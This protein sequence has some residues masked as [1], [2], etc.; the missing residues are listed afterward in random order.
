MADKRDY[1]EVLGVEKSAN[2]DDVKKAYRKLAKKFHPDMHT[3]N[4][5]EAEEKFKEVSEAYEVL[6]DPQKRQKYDQ[7]GFSGINGAFGGDGFQWQ[8][9][10]HQADVSDIF[11]DF[12]GGSIFDTFFGGGGRRRTNSGPARGSDLRLDIQITLLE[13][14][15]GLSKTLDIPHSVRCQECNGS[16]AEKGSAP[17]TCAT[18]SGSGQVKQVQRR[19]YSQ[20]ISIGACPTCQGQGQTID[21]PCKK[22][23]GQGSVRKTSRIEVNIPAGADNGTRLR[24]RGE[25]EAGA[26]GGP[27]GDLYVIVHVQEDPVFQREGRH[28]ITDMGID[29]TQAALG[30]EITINTIDGKATMKIPPGTQ[31][32][33]VFRLKG[34][35][36][37][38]MGGHGTGD[39]H[40]RVN[41]RVPEKLNA[42]Q[43]RLLKEFEEAGGGTSSGKKGIGKRKR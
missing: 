36:M 16:G 13:A 7:Y 17:K 42:E 4:K 30:D 43:K 22:C 12:F 6:A 24:L 38:A 14:A 39:L 28:L 40:V 5:A 37:P 29:F 10:T 25:G 41:I 31:P 9:F 34:K 3:E 20:Y 27:S 18:C 23:H 33:T 35:G 19:G 26:R 11:G 8:D 1:Y 21:K 2:Q 15:K 32:G